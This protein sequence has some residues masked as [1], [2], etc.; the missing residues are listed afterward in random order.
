MRTELL[1]RVRA[2]ERSL[3]MMIE[4]NRASVNV[5]RLELNKVLASEAATRD[6]LI[7]WEAPTATLAVEKL[8]HLLAHVLVGQIAFDDEALA[9]IKAQGRRFQSD[10]EN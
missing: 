1:R 6:D 10:T 2:H 5:T 9:K 4:M 8:L 7:D 3:S